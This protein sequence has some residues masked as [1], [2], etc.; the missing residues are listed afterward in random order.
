M[1]LPALTKPSPTSCARRAYGIEPA[2]PPVPL[3]LNRPVQ[4]CAVAGNHPSK[5]ISEADEGRATRCTRQKVA[6][7]SAPLILVAEVTIVADAMVLDSGAT[8]VRP[9]QAS[10][11]GALSL[12][13][14]VSSSAPA[15][16]A[17][18]VLMR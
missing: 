4:L 2:Y 8:I 15:R 1:L 12:A 10:G 6:S 18:I 11:C 14:A 13:Q 3:G 16:A 7:T 5:L 9:S 17:I